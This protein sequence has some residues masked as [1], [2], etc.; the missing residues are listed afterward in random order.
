YLAVPFGLQAA[1]DGPSSVR[2]RYR[3]PILAIL[4][5]VALVLLIACANIANLFLARA[6]S[7]RRE[8]GVHMALGASAWRLARQQLVESLLFGMTGSLAGFAIARR[9]ADLLVRQLST[10]ANTVF[11]DTHLDWRVFAFTAMVTVIVALLFGVV[12]ALRAS[13]TEATE[14]V[15]EPL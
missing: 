12:P 14:A 5:V 11:L 6:A 7:R 9:A 1:S 3:Q 4:V 15:R 8:F 10:Q 2:G 13:R